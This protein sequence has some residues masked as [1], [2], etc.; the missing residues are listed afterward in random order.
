MEKNEDDLQGRRHCRIEEPERLLAVVDGEE[1][2][3]FK[4]FLARGRG[5]FDFVADLAVEQGLADRRSRG[6]EPLIGVS[7]L[8]A[9][10]RIFDFRVALE[11]H[12]GEPGT[13][14]RAVLGDIAEVHHAEIAHAFLEMGNL[15][16]DVALALLGELVL[17]VFGEV[18]VG[19]GNGDLLGELDAELVRE[20]IDFVLELFLN[21]G[22]WVGHGIRSSVHQKRS[23]GS[24]TNKRSPEPRLRKHY[25][26]R[27]IEVK[28]GS[29]VSPQN[30]SYRMRYAYFW[31]GGK[32][33]P[34]SRGGLADI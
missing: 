24:G 18:S 14:S 23:A 22:K 31:S 6:D 10:Q 19:A 2:D 15:E 12:N 17:G 32:H 7:F 5:N 4:F 21:F 30:C 29:A 8:A 13:V 27:R 9:H 34:A 33:G 11:V 28:R 25:R 20:L 1:A 16:V 3:N 26:R